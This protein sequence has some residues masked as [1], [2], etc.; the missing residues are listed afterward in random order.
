[1][2]FVTVRDADFAKEAFCGFLPRNPISFTTG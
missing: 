2:A 1:M